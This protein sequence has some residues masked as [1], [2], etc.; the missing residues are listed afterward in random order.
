MGE[1][2]KWFVCPECDNPDTTAKQV[3]GLG[4][5][6]VNIECERC[7]FR[8]IER[9][10]SSDNWNKKI[11]VKQY[12]TGERFRAPRAS[13][14]G[15]RLVR[16]PKCDSK[17]VDF[18]VYSDNGGLGNGETVG[19]VRLDCLGCGAVKKTSVSHS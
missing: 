12:L 10:A 19:N 1:L 5:F 6:S 8:H 11:T 2:S 15:Q 18:W 4:N 16:C 3:L 14:K 7:R 13:K 17:D 9:D